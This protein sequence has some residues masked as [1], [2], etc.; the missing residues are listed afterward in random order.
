MIEVPIELSDEMRPGVVSIPHGFGHSRP[1]VGWTFAAA[2]AGASVND[3][4]DPARVDTLTGSAALDATPVR[5]E[6][7]AVEPS[8]ADDGRVVADPIP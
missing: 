3:L 5:M 7:V 1:G 6:A 2:H 4:T 8:V